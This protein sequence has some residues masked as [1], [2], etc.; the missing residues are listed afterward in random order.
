[1]KEFIGKIRQRRWTLPENFT[2][3]IESITDKKVIVEKLNKFF[4]KI[5]HSL[6]NKNVPYFDTFEKIWYCFVKW[7]WANQQVKR[8]SFPLCKE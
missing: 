8:S 6:D 2:L 1:M 3:D 4:T 7:A 5:A